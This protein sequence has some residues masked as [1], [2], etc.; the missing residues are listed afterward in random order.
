MA[1][2]ARR[3]VVLAM[4]GRL[5]SPRLAAQ[6][7]RGEAAHRDPDGRR[8][9]FRLGR[10]DH[11]RP[12]E[13][14]VVEGRT[15]EIAWRWAEGSRESMRA[16]ALE[17]MR[18]NP[19]II[20]VRSATALREARKVSGDTPMVFVSVSD[21]LGNGF[22][23]S[24]S[25]PG[26]SLTGFAN[27]DYAFAGKWLELLR[28]AA[29]AVRRVLVIQSPFNPNWPGWIRSVESAAP[30]LGLR[31]ER[32]AIRELRELEP[33]IAGFARRPDGGMIVLPDPGLSTQHE[34]AACHRD[35]ASAADRV[36]R[37]DLRS[38]RRTGLLR[39]ESAALSRDTARYV[40]RILRGEK[41][42]NLPVQGAGPVQAGGER[43]A[44]RAPSGSRCRRASSRAR[45][46]RR[47]IASRTRRIATHLGGTHGKR[48]RRRVRETRRGGH[49][50]RNIVL[51]FPTYEAARECWCSSEYQEP[52]SCAPLSRRQTSSSCALRRAPALG[53]C[54]RASPQA[55]TP[56]SRGFRPTCARS[57][58]GCAR[59]RES[60]CPTRRRRSATASRRTSGNGPV[61]YFAAFKA[62]IGFYP[63]VRGDAT[64]EKAVARYSN[65]KG[66]LRFPLDEPLPMALI[67]R[68]VRHQAKRDAARAKGR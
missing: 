29:P 39:R 24:L 35:P 66:N 25:R 61:V 41:P 10:I 22:V 63:P 52:R 4:A 45:P 32:G 37:F 31:V 3:A 27:L 42:G 57:S 5:A 17:L 59:P 54:R 64:L 44:P 56:T 43:R 65:D 19:D 60:S 30:A 67:E 9:G 50:A 13:Q 34:Y 21:P 26:G 40:D 14:R 7:V 38:R 15:A 58:N 28:E 1:S 62:H 47:L 6:R 36:R 12:R 16:Q 68:I 20:V 55:S 18:S 51:E 23:T 2:P 8:A 53:R 46:R 49:R 11:A 48:A 33:T